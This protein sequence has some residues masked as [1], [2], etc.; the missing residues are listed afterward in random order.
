M[1][2][3][4]LRSRLT[5]A[6]CALVAAL[7]LAGCV[8][9][10]QVV[11]DRTPTVLPP[12]RS[13]FYAL[14]LADEEDDAW[15]KW[16]K[17]DAL[18]EIMDIEPGERVLEIGAG[19]GGVTR[20]L[21]RAAGAQGHVTAVEND[22]RFGPALERVTARAA[23]AETVLIDRELRGPDEEPVDVVVVRN[24]Q[25]RAGRPDLLYALVRD[26]LRAG[27]RLFVVDFRAA[28]T[29]HGPPL[30]E[31]VPATAALEKWRREGFHF[32]FAYDILPLQYVLE[33]GYEGPLRRGP[34]PQTVEPRG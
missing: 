32:V 28:R 25:Y 12:E 26:R 13:P 30:R 8:R 21:I 19:T 23:N 24:F 3:S 11:D 34:L 33:F 10:S 18:V 20:R 5:P 2:G 7:A 31:R 22:E 27:G 6:R 4:P 1:P 14:V 16:Q 29:T 17:P 15:E 9:E